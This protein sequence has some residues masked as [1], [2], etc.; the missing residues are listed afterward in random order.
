MG[1]SAR[2]RVRP[3]DSDMVVLL[4]LRSLTL[5]GRPDLQAKC[6]VGLAG[7]RGG[8]AGKWSATKVEYRL[9]G[10]GFVTAVEGEGVSWTNYPSRDDSV[11]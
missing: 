11:R 7:F 6:K 10:A 8:V 3:T 9:G 2:S 5:P 1:Q 4:F